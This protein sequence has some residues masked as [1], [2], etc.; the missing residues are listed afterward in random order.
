M[1]A[2]LAFKDRRRGSRTHV[3]VDDGGRRGEGGVVEAQQGRVKVARAAA[4]QAVAWLLKRDLRMAGV[5]TFLIL[6]KLAVFYRS[7]YEHR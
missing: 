3:Q 2:L 6:P 4:P 5:G 7:L 1:R